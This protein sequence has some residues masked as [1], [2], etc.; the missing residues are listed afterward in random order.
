MNKASYRFGTQ[1]EFHAIQKQM[2]ADAD[3]RTERVS[4]IVIDPSVQPDQIAGLTM[5]SCSGGIRLAEVTAEALTELK[6][7]SRCE[8][9][10]G[11]F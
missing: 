10:A 2:N 6:R 3:K 5:L 4:F 7:L 1:A 11:S 8:R 9:I